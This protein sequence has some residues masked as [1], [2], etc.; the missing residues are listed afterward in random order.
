MS[1]VVVLCSVTSLLKISCCVTTRWPKN[2]VDVI[3]LCWGG[4][5][6][7]DL[8]FN[9]GALGRLQ[10]FIDARKLFRVPFTSSFIRVALF[11]TRLD[12]RIVTSFGTIQSVLSSLSKSLWLCSFPTCESPTLQSACRRRNNGSKEKNQ[13]SL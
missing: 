8:F 1:R 12:S 3:A 4:R 6:F 13:D 9:P 11:Q 5:S 2:S 10:S 7:S